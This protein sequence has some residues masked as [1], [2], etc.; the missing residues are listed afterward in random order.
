MFD[1]AAQFVLYIRQQNACCGI[2]SHTE[3]I[4]IDFRRTQL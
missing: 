4:L 3:Q 2:F 1:T